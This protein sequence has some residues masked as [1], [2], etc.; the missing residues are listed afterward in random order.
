MTT[1]E[2][3]GEMNHLERVSR[4]LMADKKVTVAMAVLDDVGKPALRI[5]D[6]QGSWRVIDELSSREL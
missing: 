6:L 5:L 4:K 2:R 1:E 3:N